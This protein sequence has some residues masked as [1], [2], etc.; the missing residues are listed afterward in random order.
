MIERTATNCITTFSGR[1]FWPFNPQA[2]DL[3]IDDIAHHLSLACRFSGACRTFYSVAQHSVACS[4]V[5]DK[6]IAHWALMHDAAEAYLGDMPRPIKRLLP[7]YMEAEERILEC[8]A[9]RF[10]LPWPI[11]SAV[12]EVDVRML[13]SEWRDL[14]PRG[15]LA[16]LDHVRPYDIEVQ[17][18]GPESSEAAFEMRFEEL[19]GLDWNG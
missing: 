13:A 10:A 17:P 7:D 18:V 3:D 1:P 12:K 2:C 15:H 19:F 14:M 11:P 9:H 5:C 4:L 8:V 6:S 16:Y